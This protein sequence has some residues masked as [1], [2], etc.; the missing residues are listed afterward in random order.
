LTDIQRTLPG[1]T[2]S[3]YI[4][5]WFV[6]LLQN[7]GWMGLAQVARTVDALIRSVLVAR[8]LSV[9]DFAAYAVALAFTGLVSELLNLNLGSI[10]MIYG[11]RYRE[12][13]RGGNI[14]ALLKAAYLTSVAVVALAGLAV[15]AL[16]S[17]AY[18]VFIE[19]AGLY[20]PIVI[21]GF[22]TAITLLDTFNKSVLRSLDRFKA[23][24]ITDVATSIFGIAFMFAILRMVPATP[25]N[26]IQ[27]TSFCLALSGAA[28]TIV[29]W[30]VI[31]QV[32]PGWRR[33]PLSALAR[34][35][36]SILRMIVGVSMSYVLSRFIRKGDV[37][38]LAAFAPAT[39]VG[40]FD[41]G[42]KLAGFVLLARDVLALAAF[43]QIAKS[44]AAGRNEELRSLIKWS[45]LGGGPIAMLLLVFLWFLA[46]PVVIFLFGAHYAAAGAIFW[47]LTIVNS[48]YLL[49]FWGGP[50]LASNRRVRALL[51]SAILGLVLMTSAGIVLAPRYEAA[52]MAVAVLIGGVA[53]FGFIL[54][55]AWLDLSSPERVPRRRYQIEGGAR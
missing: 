9:E 51:A 19:R 18:G 48:C 29:T 55:V 7:S 17:V 25:A 16:L 26:A 42:K 49:F 21:L 33:A 12:A 2:E 31:S 53:Q 40:I 44:I 52:G 14:R 5:Q 15:A 37:L 10:F 35:A 46:E 28:S 39:A 6:M 47:I 34:D 32:T 36:S 38:L 50:F 30:R 4:K 8:A 45:L 22:A 41:V 23:N 3:S 13:G 54:T 43:P 27:A 20:G 24:C 1:A 11:A